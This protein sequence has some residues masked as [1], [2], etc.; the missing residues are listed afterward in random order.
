MTVQVIDK[1]WERITKELK[2]INGTHVKVG[3][4]GE[5]VETDVATV[6]IINEFGAPTKNIPPRPF[7]A[8]TYDKNRAKIKQFKEKEL[9]S[10]FEG[11]QTVSGA[12]DKLGSWFSD[13]VKKEIRAGSFEANKPATIVK[14]GSSKPLIDDGIMIGSVDFEVVSK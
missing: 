14:K 13:Q 6:A 7:M 9:S 8:N 12:M 3:F 2:F 5:K 10:I 11:K 1:G 4:P